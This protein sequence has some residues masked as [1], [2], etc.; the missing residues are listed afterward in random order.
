M[1]PVQVFP[2][3]SQTQLLETFPPQSSHLLAGYK[4]IVYYFLGSNFL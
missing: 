4:E 3:P 1:H 2:F